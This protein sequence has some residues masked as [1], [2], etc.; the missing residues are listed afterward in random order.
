M[1]ENVAG[2]VSFGNVGEARWY[3][4]GAFASQTAYVAV[5]FVLITVLVAVFTHNFLSYGNL[6]NTSKNF[7]YIAI[8]A[9]GS[10]LV[11]ITGGID[12][13]VGSVMALVAVL[14]VILMKFFA[15]TFVAS[16]PY[17][18][19]T[20]A[21]LGGLL[22]SAL[23]GLVNGLL[24]S[25]IRL[26][27]FVTTLGMLSICRG[28]TY[29]ITQGRGQAPAGPQVDTFYSLTDGKLFGLP[30]PLVYLL[31]LAV[32][33][34]VALRQTRWGRY[35]FVLGGNE[36]AA[37]LT[38]VAVS[39]VKISVYILCAMSAGFAGI[40]IAG[41]LGSAPANLATGYELKIIAASVI[42]GADLAGGVGG[43]V[44]AVIGAALIEVIRNGLALFGADT[45]WEQVFVGTIIILAV[46]VDRLRTRE[47]E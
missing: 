11:I 28:A 40:L 30:V 36:R 3:R 39:R 29:V 44:G 42:G 41:W 1:S 2:P 20:L 8:V 23:V 35:V 16:I 45:Y 12:L 15:T 33:M 18:G 9:L 5:A 10:T 13:S 6:L 46:L 27:P 47:A 38:G 21:V 4:R 17:L 32:V 24:I 26:S 37:Q 7:S 19:I 22:V 34:G 43:P 25:K 31:V 14:T